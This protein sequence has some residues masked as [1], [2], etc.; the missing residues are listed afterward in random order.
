MD[1]LR[2]R[3]ATRKHIL[4]VQVLL[5]ANQWHLACDIR[6]AASAYKALFVLANMT[7]TMITVAELASECTPMLPC[8][9]VQKLVLPC[10]HCCRSH[11][12]NMYVKPNCTA[13]CSS[14]DCLVTLAHMQDAHLQLSVYHPAYITVCK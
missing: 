4:N 6:P 7:S 2:Q 13:V 8:C 1:D 9:I 10:R 14:S 3:A 11:P 12:C 5:P